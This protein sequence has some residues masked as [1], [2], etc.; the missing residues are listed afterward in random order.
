M[1][2]WFSDLFSDN[3]LVSS[4]RVGFVWLLFNAIAMGWF[5][6]ICGTEHA[7]EAG[8]IITT[9]SSVAAGMKLYQKQQEIDNEKSSNGRE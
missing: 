6:L 8:G 9:V 3:G 2:K 5:V 4:T 1:K 7:L